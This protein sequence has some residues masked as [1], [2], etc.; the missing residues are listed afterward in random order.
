[1]FGGSEGKLK[2][3]MKKGLSA[4]I[5]ATAMLSETM[6]Q[7]QQSQPTRPSHVMKSNIGRKAYQKRKKRL[8]MAKQ[9]RRINRKP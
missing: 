2:N 5:L 6:T 3:D 4:L 7:P 8:A 9:S 1:L